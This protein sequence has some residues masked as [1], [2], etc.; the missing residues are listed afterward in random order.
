MALRRSDHNYPAARRLRRTMSLPER[1]LWRELRGSPQ[2]VKL[3]RQH[4]VG[5]YVIDFYCA[6]A[7]AG[8]EIYGFS[9]GTGDRTER[10]EIRTLWLADQG[11]A[12]VRIPASEV[13]AYPHAVAA[14]IVEHC[15][16][17]RA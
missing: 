16:S 2:G 8:F 9:H 13:L 3:R 15:L 11:I 6:S 5:R 4:P 10:D 17:H 12:I 14:S 7:K 1:L